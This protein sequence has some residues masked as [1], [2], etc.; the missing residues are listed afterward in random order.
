MVSMPD[1]GAPR[2]IPWTPSAKPMHERAT[3]A[4]LARCWQARVAAQKSAPADRAARPAVRANALP[5]ARRC[6]GIRRGLFT[7]VAIAERKRDSSV[8]G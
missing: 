5:H 4:I 2:P 6:A 8:V 7:K 1:G 3:P